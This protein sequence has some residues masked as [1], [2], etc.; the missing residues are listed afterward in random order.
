MNSG[1][2]T[3]CSEYERLRLQNIQRND[4]YLARIG[5][6]RTTTNDPDIQPR[7]R[8]VAEQVRKAVP[9]M[10]EPTRRSPRVAL[11]PIT[12]YKEKNEV[13]CKASATAIKDV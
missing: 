13:R 6:S 3:E 12:N 9:M 7:K 11:L 10:A 1:E 4:E 8:K 5:F 2:S